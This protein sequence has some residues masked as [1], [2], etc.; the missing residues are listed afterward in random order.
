MWRLIDQFEDA[1]RTHAPKFVAYMRDN[2]FGRMETLVGRATGPQRLEA[3][4]AGVVLEGIRGVPS[5]TSHI[6]S[7]HSHLK[8][9]AVGSRCVG[10][11]TPSVL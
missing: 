8:A 6:E 7:Y 3:A 9:G 11:A 5:T 10:A 4:E 2:W 1:W